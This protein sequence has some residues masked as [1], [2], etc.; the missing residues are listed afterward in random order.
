M[1]PVDAERARQLSLFR[2]L[3]YQRN[4]CGY[5][6]SE[7]GSASY[8]ASSVA[9]RPEHYG[10]LIDR[11]WRRSGSLYYKQNLQRSCCPHYTL[12][13]EASAYQPR[14]DQR[15]A[16]NAW[17]KF[18]LGPEYMR[19]AARLCPR[20]REEK[21][22]RK[23]NFDL[24]SA[25]HESE[26]S[27]VK[28]PIDP[29]T[30]RPLEPAHRFEVN[31][32]GDS[33]SQTKFE[34]FSKY[35]T[36]VHRE[37]VS[38]WK[39]KDFERFLC[40]GIKRSPAKPT[41]ANA[42]EKKLGSWHQC[43]RLDGKLIAVAVLDLVPNGVSSV[44]VFYDPEY[45]HWQFGKLSA[46][47]EIAFCIENDYPFYYMGY[48]I[49]SCVKMRYKGDF[50]PQYILDPETNEWDP[51]AG[52]LTEKLNKRSYVSLSRDR[53]RSTNAEDSTSSQP[54]DSDINEEELSLFDLHMPGVLTMDE[55]E[56]LDLDH[57]HLLYHGTFVNMSVTPPS[58]LS[59]SHLADSIQDLVG[60][61]DMPMN[62]PQSLKGIIAE[63]A[64]VL[65]PTL[66]KDS[67]VVLFD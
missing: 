54:I 60:W 63:L 59:L 12:R 64:A 14:R 47:R 6:K 46:M 9:V 2:P 3:G 50:R 66:V 5:C 49:H 21:R 55:V 22:H 7:D 58:H 65:G 16:I 45:E 17:T 57:W 19:K 35:Q 53:S 27:N 44:Y 43:Y 41:K 11:G 48:Y 4:S 28:R 15:K 67:A 52:E 42:D 62:N 31:I 20:T 18:V 34:L 30:K 40:A 38:R 13:L 56:A 37:D 10:E 32:E 29:E 25:V 39:T 8:Y 36:K 1:E 26:Y 33:V 61:E 23:C 51:L 24:L